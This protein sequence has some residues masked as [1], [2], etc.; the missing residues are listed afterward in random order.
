MIKRFTSSAT[1][2]FQKNYLFGA[3]MTGWKR[4][5]QGRA[6]GG[7]KGLNEGE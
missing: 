1:L 6:K 5:W 7:G 3:G 2:F 4:E